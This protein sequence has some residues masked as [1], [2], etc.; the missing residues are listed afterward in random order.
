M[1]KL[2]PEI[3]LFYKLHD[4]IDKIHKIYLHAHS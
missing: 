1:G 3:G 4:Y 2:P